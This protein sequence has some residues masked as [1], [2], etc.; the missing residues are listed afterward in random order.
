MENQ[1]LPVALLD[2]PK[3]HRNGKHKVQ[4]FGIPKK[5][6]PP[7]PLISIVIPAYQEEKL[8]EKN[9]IYLTENHKS[10][11][12]YELIVSDGGST[13]R[14]VEISMKYA[15]ITVMHNSN[16]RQNISQGRNRGAERANGDIFVF[17]NA[18]S[19]P[20]DLDTFFDFIIKWHSGDSEYSDAAAFA[21]C[22]RS[23]PDEEIF[24][25]KVFYFIHNS[26]VR[27]LNSFGLGM[28]RGECQI[29]RKD[30]FNRIGGYNETIFAGEDFDLYRRISKIGRVHY[31]K[32]LKICESPR[33][34]RKYGYLKII[35]SW[36]LNA[37]SVWLYGRSVAKE[38]EPVR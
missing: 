27:L 22:V 14:T 10:K 5:K 30:L 23:M 28:G 34:F 18:D 3:I 20:A 4:Q 37:L 13:D 19:I 35:I 36:T 7:K 2:N 32:E 25:D 15:D 33:R 16:D 6:E 1:L 17:L 21:C 38:W 8:I 29:V 9:L 12:N 11:Y 31:V 26:Y 24:K